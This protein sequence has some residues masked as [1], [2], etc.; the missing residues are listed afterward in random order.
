MNGERSA[1]RPSARGS[2]SYA[3]LRIFRRQVFRKIYGEVTAWIAM[4]SAHPSLSGLVIVLNL[5]PFAGVTRIR[6]RT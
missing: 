2:R 1:T 6:E 4:N 5:L 3:E